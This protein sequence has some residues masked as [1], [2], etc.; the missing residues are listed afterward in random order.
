MEPIDSPYDV[1]QFG[2][3]V[4]GKAEVI[5]TYDM[6]GFQL[7]YYDSSQGEYVIQPKDFLWKLPISSC[8]N[9]NE[10]GRIPF[11]HAY[12]IKHYHRDGFDCLGYLG[13]ACENPE[14]FEYLD[15]PGLLVLLAAYPDKAKRILSKRASRVEIVQE[16]TGSDHIRNFHINWL[17][18]V[19][20]GTVSPSI[21]AEKL[22][23]SILKIHAID[24]KVRVDSYAARLFK[25]F[26]HQ[27]QWE[28]RGLDFARMLV[29]RDDAV[30]DDSDWLLRSYNGD[31]YKYFYESR[32]ALKRIGMGARS[33]LGISEEDAPPL[34]RL[35]ALNLVRDDDLL[36]LGFSKKLR[37]IVSRGSGESGLVDCYVLLLSDDDI[38]SPVVP[39]NQFVTHLDTFEK[40]R[41]QAINAKNCLW[42]LAILNKVLARQ[43]DLYA[44]KAENLYTIS[45]DRK[46]LDI[47][48][49]EASSGNMIKPRDL[50]VIADWFEECTRLPR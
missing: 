26:A 13:L 19:R 15:N 6:L 2:D 27:K 48:M 46:T 21:I 30:L 4:D 22:Q 18:K 39:G 20:P 45:V 33:D 12:D 47:R 29:R 10:I 5:A 40:I 14:L 35:R 32:R 9:V 3:S 16:L 25:L 17:K 34:V 44:V 28:S 11:P 23:Q 24:V 50:R 7:Y 1:L 38:P 36:T 49:I 41:A 42:S 8:N 37:R 43:F 31:K